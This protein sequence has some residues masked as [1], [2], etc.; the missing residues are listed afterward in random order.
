MKPE[1]I[2]K[3]AI[4]KAVK[5]GWNGKTRYCL[6][7]KMDKNWIEPWMVYDMIF[8]HDFAKAFFPNGMRYRKVKFP[9]GFYKGTVHEWQYHLQQM[10]LEKDPIKYLKKFV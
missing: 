9:F 7:R 10:V 1:T 4:E 5:N 3:K 8:S 6:Y 2:L